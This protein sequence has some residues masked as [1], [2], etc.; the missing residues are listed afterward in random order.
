MPLHGYA[1]Q[2]RVT[3]ED[4][5]NNF[6]PDYGRIHDLPLAGRLRHPARRRHRRTAARSS[7]RSTTRCW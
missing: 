3:T 6:I 1:L 4:P 7:R 5:E 2:C